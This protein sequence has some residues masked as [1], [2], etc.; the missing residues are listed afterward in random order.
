MTQMKFRLV[1]NQKENCHYDDI[2]F[3]N[4]ILLVKYQNG[5]CHN[6]HIPFTNGIP[7]G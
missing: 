7:F 2:P 4:G 6:D 3:T 5:N 1:N